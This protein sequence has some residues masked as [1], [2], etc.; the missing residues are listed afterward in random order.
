MNDPGAHPQ[1]R[2]ESRGLPVRALAPAKINLGL[3]VGPTRADGRHELVSVMQSISLAD[4]LTLEY[5]PEGAR[6]D[7]LVCPGVDGPPAENLAARAL[8]AFRRASGWEAPPLRLSV[9]KR[10]PVAAGLAGGSA[11]AAAALRL[12]AYASCLGAGALGGRTVDPAGLG[13]SVPGRTADPAGLGG[14]SNLRELGAGLGADVPAQVV[15]GRWLA[16]GAGELLDELPA[17]NTSFGVLVL[18]VAAELSAGE[19]YAQVDRLGAT[20]ERAELRDR[21]RALHGALDLG[22]PA[23]PAELLVNDLE[24]A[25]R[26]LCPAIAQ[27]LAQAR[28]G[29][30]D[31]VFVS[32]SGPTVIGLFLRANG[33]VRAQRAAAGLADRSPAPICATPVTAEFGRA[34]AIPVGNN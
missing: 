8:A 31:A 4:E 24:A 5:A 25:A 27:A 22:T 16:G 2:G 9:V 20:R 21:H 6:E 28:E 23:P 34:A 13:G 33:L 18:P 1:T 26:S 12:A 17:P 30:A 3:F 19:V 7:E 11:D 10:I 15:P 29:G 32:G 14:V